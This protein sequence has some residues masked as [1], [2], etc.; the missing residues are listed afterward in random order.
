MSTANRNASAS[1]AP[2]PWHDLATYYGHASLKLAREHASPTH[3][4]AAIA[5]DPDNVNPS[6]WRALKDKP[7]LH[8]HR[9]QA[10]A[11]I[12][13]YFG[14]HIAYRNIARWGA[15]I[16]K[17]DHQRVKSQDALWELMPQPT[18]PCIDQETIRHVADEVASGLTLKLP[19]NVDHR[20]H[21]WILAALKN[22]A[23][24]P[25]TKERL[26]KFY[27]VIFEN[28]IIQENTLLGY[29]NRDMLCFLF[30]D[31]YAAIDFLN[32]LPTKDLRL[33]SRDQLCHILAREHHDPAPYDPPPMPPVQNDNETIPDWKKIWR[34]IHHTHPQIES[35][36]TAMREIFE[37]FLQVVDDPKPERID[38][39]RQIAA[40]A[41]QHAQRVLA[42]IFFL[43]SKPPQAVI[44]HD[45]VCEPLLAH[46]PQSLPAECCAATLGRILEQ[47]KKPKPIPILSG[48][49]SDILDFCY[50]EVSPSRRALAY[51][52]ALA[53]AQ[54]GTESEKKRIANRFS[55]S[56]SYCDLPAF[57]QAWRKICQLQEQQQHLLQHPA[58]LL[59]P[60]PEKEGS[61]YG[62][63]RNSD[64]RQQAEDIVRQD[65]FAAISV[66]ATLPADALPRD[67]TPVLELIARSDRSS[68]GRRIRHALVEHFGHETLCGALT[69]L[70]LTAE[71]ER[72]R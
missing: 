23:V 64:M 41:T 44:L 15:K 34:F 68:Y 26:R 63:R 22:N 14:Q 3:L 66:I 39:L 28:T 59:M 57:S 45:V 62:Y 19:T 54:N 47:G 31:T 55:Y 67:S 38:A 25:E 52:W 6:W 27:S 71:D 9:E 29:Q 40:H 11:H 10:I 30:G 61:G 53:Q 65:P 51:A 1:S 21:K 42:K 48:M 17:L 69:S 16:L 50:H 2:T 33:H 43:V 7:D 8:H 37:N 46:E 35:G 13:P 70:L 58:A 12:D 36:P 18:I 49:L 20:A 56:F 32:Y 5:T 60:T 72:Q 24:T 4:I